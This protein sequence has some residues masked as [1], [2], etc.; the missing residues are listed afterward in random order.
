MMNI[1][2]CL[3]VIGIIILLL[4]IYDTKY[5]NIT[6]PP[7]SFDANILH[8]YNEDDFE[9]LPGNVFRKE[10]RSKSKKYHRKNI[11]H[12]KKSHTHKSDPDPY[13]TTIPINPYFMELQYHPDYMDTTNA[14]N[15]LLPQ[16]HKPLFN[17][18]DLPIILTSSPSNTEITSLVTNFIKEVNKTINQSVTTTIDGQTPPKDWKENYPTNAQES[19]W[20]VQMKKL[21]IPNT[22]YTH[23]APKA[24]ISLIKVD[25]SEKMETNDEIQYTIYI[26]I[27]K[28]NAD[29]Q[30][31]LKLVFQVDK[32]DPNDDR[33]FFKPHTDANTDTIV[34]IEEIYVMGFYTTH[35]FGK[36][37]VKNEYYNFDGVTDGR[38][39]SQKEILAELNKK[40][41]Q[42]NEE[43]VQ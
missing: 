23:P 11:S 1:Y 32:Q 5:N 6:R 38:M 30:M 2:D 35:S 25:H 17:R 3:L 21:G 29:D 8:D 18:S 10:K 12:R 26:V 19:G 13:T 14:F 15:L 41:K 9:N 4:V 16:T 42:Y 31:M 20:D 27:Q 43:C 24:P 36:K 37:S 7:E 33:D 22:I 28:P 34:K 40:R 39:F